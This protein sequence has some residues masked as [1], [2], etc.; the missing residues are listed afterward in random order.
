[1]E[2]LRYAAYR[3][4]LEALYFS[5]AYRAL[6]VRFGGVG[7][8]LTLHHVRPPRDGG[9][10]PNRALEIEADFLER[11]VVHLRRKGVDLVGIGEVRRRLVDEDFARRRA[12]HSGG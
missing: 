3:A 2:S 5:G 4:G 6:G 1:M 8:I 9:F 11:V 12:G 10:Q 7:A